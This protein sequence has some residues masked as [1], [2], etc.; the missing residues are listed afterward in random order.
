MKITLVCEPGG[1]IGSHP[2]RWLKQT[3]SGSGVWL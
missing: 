1:F 3:D 2:V